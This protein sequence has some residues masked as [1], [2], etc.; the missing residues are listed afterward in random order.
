MVGHLFCIGHLFRA[1]TK[2]GSLRYF[3]LQRNEK[4]NHRHINDNFLQPEIT[5]QLTKVDCA[6]IEYKILALFLL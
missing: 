2:F 4:K 6:Y 1:G 5:F 3:D